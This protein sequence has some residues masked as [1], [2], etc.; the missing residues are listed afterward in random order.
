M[1]ELAAQKLINELKD[2]NMNKNKIENGQPTLQ[3][4]RVVC[5]YAMSDYQLQLK[6]LIKC[7]DEIMQAGLIFPAVNYVQ[8]AIKEVLEAMKTEALNCVGVDKD[9]EQV[10]K[11]SST[12]H[13][14]NWR[15]EFLEWR[16]EKKGIINYKRVE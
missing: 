3:Q 10:F 15:D 8:D 5:S 13:N 2:N 4:H 9:I 1:W 16:K 11:E 6:S 7:Q 14:W 12:N